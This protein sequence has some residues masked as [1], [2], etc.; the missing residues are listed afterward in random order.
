MVYKVH[1]WLTSWSRHIHKQLKQYLCSE[2]VLFIHL[3]AQPLT[4]RLSCSNY[5]L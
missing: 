1:D 3:I 4:G 5:I 2:K